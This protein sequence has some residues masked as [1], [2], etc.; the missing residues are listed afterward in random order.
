[1]RRWF[2][3][4]LL[5]SASAF[6]QRIPL[7]DLGTRSYLAQ[8][9]G[10][11]YEGGSNAIPADHAAS[12]MAHAALIRPLDRNGNPSA[13]GKIV[14]L[15]IGMSNT[16][17]EFCAQGNPAPCETWSFVGQATRDAAVNHSTLLFVNGARGGQTGDT[18]DAPTQP[19]YDYVRDRDLTPAGVSEA[20]VQVAWLKEAN[21]Q[22]T[23]S[24]PAQN[25][26][27]FRMVTQFGKIL[28][29][30]KVRYPNLHIVYLSSR[31][32][33]G[34][35]TS[36]LNPEPYAYE[37]AFAVKWAVQAQIDQMR[38]GQIDA[39][40][41]DLNSNGVAPWIAWGPYLWAD[42]M[43]PRSDGLTWSRSD[44]ESSDGTHPAQ[45][46]EQK[47]GAMLLAFLKQEPTARPWFLAGEAPPRRRAIG[48]H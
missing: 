35:A 45:S 9:Q 29:A 12:G 37:T 6:G 32:Y 39:R 18:W 38:S 10:G 19:N 2:A 41:G 27:A 42:G 26:D 30:M 33:A 44:V 7:S 4:V 15:S 34:Y 36:S 31:I 21:P 1:M 46:G 47:V 43:N 23:S 16:T 11:L 13:T 25:A 14:M 8:Y 20:Q 22:P 5:V 40:A 17:Q 3:V 48:N 28:R 24:L